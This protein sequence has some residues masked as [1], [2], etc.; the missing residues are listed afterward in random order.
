M[1][2]PRAAYSFIGVAPR[3]VVKWAAGQAIFYAMLVICF[4]GGAMA[5]AL[6]TEGARRR[7]ARAP[8]R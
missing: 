4:L 2:F 6:M 7:G 8:R 3:A 5:S 1:R